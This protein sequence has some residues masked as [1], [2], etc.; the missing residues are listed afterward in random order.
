M[1]CPLAAIVFGLTAFH[2]LFFAETVDKPGCGGSRYAE[3][4]GYLTAEATGRSQH[5]PKHESLWRCQ[6]EFCV[7]NCPL[8]LHETGE[9]SRVE[10]KAVIEHQCSKSQSS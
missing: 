1:D 2:Q 3:D 10:V 9:G 8:S 4:I 5:N 6:P 7:H